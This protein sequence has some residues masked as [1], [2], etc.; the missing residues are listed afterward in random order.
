MAFTSREGRSPIDRLS[1]TP[2]YN[3]L[4]EEIV[5]ATFVAFFLR[6]I[7]I[8]VPRDYDS[9]VVSKEVAEHVEQS[10][11]AFTVASL[12]SSTWRRALIVVATP[13]IGRLTPWV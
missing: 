8:L 7:R 10:T 11:T 2:G 13:W 6:R 1:Y 12:A 5:Y 9:L 4:K 3:M